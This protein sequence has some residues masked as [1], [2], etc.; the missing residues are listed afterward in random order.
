MAISL[1]SSLKLSPV[2]FQALNL[3]KLEILSNYTKC[4]HSVEIV[5]VALG[6]RVMASGKRATRV[7]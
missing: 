1:S 6:P 5:D 4:S 3:I 2:V 7:Q